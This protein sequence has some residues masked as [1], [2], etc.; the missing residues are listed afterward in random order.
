MSIRGVRID[1]Q[2]ERDGHVCYAAK[3]PAHDSSTPLASCIKHLQANE[4]TYAV[5]RLRKT[6]Q[7]VIVGLKGPLVEKVYLRLAAKRWTPPASR[8]AF[9]GYIPRGKVLSV[10]KVLKNGTRRE[11]TVNQ[12]S[13]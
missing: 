9:F 3:L 7:L 13:P 1:W 12:Y 4:V 8:G 10:V 2:H 6:R 5:R 11:F